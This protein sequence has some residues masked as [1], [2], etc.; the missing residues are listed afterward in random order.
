MS[1][2]SLKYLKANLASLKLILLT[3]KH[4]KEL[5][6]KKIK[7]RKKRVWVKPWIEKRTIQNQLYLELEEDEPA[8]FRQCFRM[9]P[10]TFHKL[11]N[12]VFPLILKQNT[13]M[14]N[15]IPPKTRLQVSFYI[16]DEKIRNKF[17]FY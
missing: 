15:A 5:E 8:K 9:S 10:K 3:R 17:H 1:D 13:S 12:M 14:R 7:N 2:K 16:C 4:K 6:E 11:L